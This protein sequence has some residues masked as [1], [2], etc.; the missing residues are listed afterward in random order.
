MPGFAGRCQLLLKGPVEVPEG[1]GDVL[2]VEPTGLQEGLSPMVTEALGHGV[3]CPSP[4]GIPYL[5]GTVLPVSP[6]RSRQLLQL[7][8]EGRQCAGFSGKPAPVVGL[9]VGDPCDDSRSL[10]PSPIG[11]P[12]RVG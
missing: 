3:P 8:P 9:S 2:A 10:P 11:R 12:G 4:E 7:A 5:A 6:P 1:C